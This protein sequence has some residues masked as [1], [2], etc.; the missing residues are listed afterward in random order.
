MVSS[1]VDGIE[2]LLEQVFSIL[3]ENYTVWMSYK[4]TIRVNSGK[5]NFENCLEAVEKCDLFLGILTTSYGSGKDKDGLSITHKEVRAAIK[6][7]IPRWF[8]S[9]RD[10][11]FAFDLVR[12]LGF[13][14]P[15]NVAD[16]NEK[17]A[18]LRTKGRNPV[19]DDYNVLVMYSEVIQAKKDLIERR[20]NW[21]Q[22]FYTDRDGQ[23]FVT[24]QF[25]RH[26]QVIEEIKNGPLSAMNEMTKKGRKK[27]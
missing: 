2:D 17:M 14:I 24:A 13:R 5:S 22:P 19:I 1:T 10:L 16:L 25:L 12:N 20:G 9:H 11:E 8:L 3:N 21:A 27:P 15:E 18:T 7:D 4:G 26:T 23:I 6:R